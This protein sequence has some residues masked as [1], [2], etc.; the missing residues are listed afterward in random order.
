MGAMKD[1]DLEHILPTPSQR[2][3]DKAVATQDVE[4]APVVSKAEKPVKA[5]A[6]ETTTPKKE[7][8]PAVNTNALYKG[9]KNNGTGAG[10]GTGSIPGNQGSRLGDPLASNYGEGGSMATQC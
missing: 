2:V 5:A 4:D 9:N 1:K 10:D 8:T 6:T 7:S 3:S